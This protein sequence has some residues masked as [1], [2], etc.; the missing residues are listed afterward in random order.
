M[1]ARQARRLAA[2]VVAATLVGACG[3]GPSATPPA[4]A[5]DPLEVYRA[6]AAEIVEIRGLDAPDRADPQ[7]IDPEQ[8]RENYEAAFD[9]SN[10]DELIEVSERVYRALGLI[11]EDAS[12]REIFLELNGSQVIGYYDSKADELFIV[13]R[14]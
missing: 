9:D 3:D 7:L 4:S 10:P 11:P 2:L 1:P 6:I 13:S 8:L 14:S 5:A 12:L